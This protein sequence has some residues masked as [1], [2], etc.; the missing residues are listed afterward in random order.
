MI[1]VQIEPVE[2]DSRTSFVAHC[3]D[4][5]LEF[6]DEFLRHG[7]TVVFARPAED[8]V[9]AVM[10]FLYAHCDETLNNFATDNL[11]QSDAVF[12]HDM[13]DISHARAARLEN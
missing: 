11:Y 4:L 6:V 9:N 7:F 5:G 8:Y 1:T 13:A 3:S 10:P 12:P 2:N